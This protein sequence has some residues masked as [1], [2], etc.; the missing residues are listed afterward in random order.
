MSEKVADYM[1]KKIESQKK[2]AEK[3]EKRKK[4]EETKKRQ[5]EFETINNEDSK[6]EPQKSS[7]KNKLKIE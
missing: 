1:E 7:K 4:I 6:N 2:L 5:Q 3:E